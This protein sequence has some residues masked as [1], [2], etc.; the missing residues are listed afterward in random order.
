MAAAGG[1]QRE[2]NSSMENSLRSALASWILCWLA[3]CLS[4]S[5][6]HIRSRAVINA[7]DG[8]SKGCLSPKGIVMVRVGG[9]HVNERGSKTE[10]KTY[11]NRGGLMLD[12]KLSSE[13][14]FSSLKVDA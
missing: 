14:M 7:E 2:D 3:R 12:E 1:R 6:S 5:S 11:N 4:R 9:I 10:R 8:S 13:N